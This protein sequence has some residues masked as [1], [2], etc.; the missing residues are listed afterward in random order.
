MVPG[1]QLEEPEFPL[2]ELVSRSEEPE[3]L[4]AELV[5]QSGAPGFLSEGSV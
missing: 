1:S 5:S 2:A 3:F 4:L